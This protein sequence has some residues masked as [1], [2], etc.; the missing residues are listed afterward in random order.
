MAVA[1]QITLTMT[2][3]FKH[4][5]G[6]DI[7]Q[8]SVATLFI[9]L[10]L[11]VDDPVVAGDSVKRML[12]EG[13]PPLVAAWLGPTKLAHAILFATIT[14]IVAY[15]PF[16]ALTGTTGEFLFSLPVVMT[17]ALVASRLVSMTFIP[18]LGY[19]L[20][21]PAEKGGARREER[22]SRAFSGFYYRVG[23]FVIDHR[24]KSFAVSLL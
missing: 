13:H 1:I 2:F 12:A 22:R 17:C 19:Y 14:N 5:L 9:A 18:F 6:V 11:L 4:L 3:A 16:L 21:R 15:V 23:T 20:L 24:W 8:M 10:G 7:K